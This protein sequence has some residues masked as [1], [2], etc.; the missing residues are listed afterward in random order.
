MKEAEW[1][2]SL[3]ERIL[4]Q[5]DYSREL[6]DEE[7][8]DL[9]DEMMLRDE[10]VQMFSVQSR[11]RVRRELFDSLRRL[12]I[13]QMF[14]DDPD[15]TEIMINGK[16]RMFAERH[17]Q[18][19]ELPIRFESSEKL[20]Q[21]IQ[22]IVAGCNRVVNEASPIVDAR[23]ENG[24]RVNIVMQP[25]ALN[26]PVVT[27]RRFPER[28]IR[29]EDLLEKQSLTP[30]AAQLLKVLVEAGYNIFISGGTGSGK[31][32]LLN[33]LSGYIPPVERVITI[34]D[35]A[36]L[37]LQGIRNLVSLEVRN[38]NLEGCREITIRDLIKTSL[39]M[40]P[41]RLVVGEVRSEEAAD[42]L[43]AMNTGAEGS[44]ST[45]HANS[46]ADML[47]RLETMTRMGMDIPLQAIREQIGSGI[48]ILIHLGR[49]PDHSRRVLEIVELVG[50]DGENYRLNPLFSFETRA[51]QEQSG[52]QLCRKGELIRVEKL[53]RAGLYRA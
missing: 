23:L 31:T 53:Q 14:V 6:S 18:L 20:M 49:L 7:V 48:D 16:D 26:G 12:D 15:I 24:A 33:V 9:I 51:G 8:E 27:I 28:P 50:Y 40:R 4:Q 37:Q 22:Q 3:K 10:K 35:N 1:K 2:Q 44:M 52:G 21:V 19:E 45:G 13:L 36:E 5:I 39:R 30:E 47:R 29:M 43:Q 46:A 17:G 42:M 38:S 32:T 34:E 11:R 25:V 41:D